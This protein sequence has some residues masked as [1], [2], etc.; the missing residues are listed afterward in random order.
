[1]KKH[2]LTEY[3][4]S[5]LNIKDVIDRIMG[6][7]GL[8]VLFPIF[9]GI[10]IA[11]KLEDGLTAPVLFSQKRVGKNKEFFQLYKFRSMKTDT[12]HDKLTH[13]LENPEQ[14]ITNVGAF[15]RKTLFG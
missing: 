9:L 6:A 14:Y 10:I 4:K 3:Q 8:A 5:Y 1:M 12:P 15:L 2:E 13:M 11:I 7:A